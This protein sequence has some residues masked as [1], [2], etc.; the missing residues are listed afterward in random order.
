MRDAVFQRRYK[1]LKQLIDRRLAL[2]AP[3][4]MP[5]DLFQGSQY[6]LTA[7]GKRVRATILL[8]CCEAVGGSIKDAIDAALAIEMLHNFTLVR[9][10]GRKWLV[11]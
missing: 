8:L 11:C 1:S 4:N 2:V 10:N 5:R 6:V 7:P 3:R 9:N